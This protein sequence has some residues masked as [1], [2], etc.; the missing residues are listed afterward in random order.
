MTDIITN[1]ATHSEAF[2]HARE[3]LDLYLEPLDKLGHPSPRA[4][5]QLVLTGFETA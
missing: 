3:A 5:Y 2:G 1:G 4:R